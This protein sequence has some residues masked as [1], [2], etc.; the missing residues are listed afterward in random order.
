MSSIDLLHDLTAKLLGVPRG[1]VSPDLLAY[2]ARILARF[3]TKKKS[4]GHFTL[5]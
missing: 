1:Q 4:N 5:G 3:A 2:L